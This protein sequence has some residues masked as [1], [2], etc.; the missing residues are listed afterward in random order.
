MP[1]IADDR[2]RESLTE[3]LDHVQVGFVRRRRVRGHAMQQRKVLVVSADRLVRDTYVV[4][5]LHAGGYHQRHVGLSCL[6]QQHH[7]SGLAR[8]NLHERHFEADEKV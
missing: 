5:S 3:R 6:L 1:G 2:V 8:A 7:V 4:Q